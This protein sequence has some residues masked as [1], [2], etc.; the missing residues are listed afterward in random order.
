MAS[1]SLSV[2]ILI[3]STTAAKDPKTDSSTQLLRDFFKAENDNSGTK[4]TWKVAESRIVSDDK[5]AIQSAV[6][7][8]ADVEKLHLIVTTGGTGFAVTDST[9]EACL[10]YTGALKAMLR[11]Y[12]R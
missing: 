1:T 9:P 12:R 4:Y 7:E 3:V 10:D 2:G 6:R 5:D 8:W 11:E